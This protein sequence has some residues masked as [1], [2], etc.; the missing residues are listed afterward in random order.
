MAKKYKVPER[1]TDENVMDVNFFRDDIEAMYED[2]DKIENLANK[3][4][5]D[6]NNI[7]FDSGTREMIGRGI[8]NFTSEQT[9]NLASLRTAKNTALNQIVQTK[10]K[11][12]QMTINKNKEDAA[13]DTASE[14][15][16]REFQK[17]FMTSTRDSNKQ[18]VKYK[19]IASSEDMKSNDLLE[20]RIKELV[21]SGDLVFTDNEQAIKYEKRGVIIKVHNSEPMY[22]AAF[23]ADTN[24]L[25]PD[26]PQTLLPSNDILS[27]TTILPSG[28]IRCS[29]GST[30]EVF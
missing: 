23:T 12:A 5:V 16:R 11:I 1:L 28:L 3:V 26:Y 8:L 21:D 4:E 9:K 14:A 2:V 25:I 18:E 13:N 6:L 27:E 20:N 30:Y 7:Y 22:F 15:A 10:I 19:D 17:L 29:N 24:E